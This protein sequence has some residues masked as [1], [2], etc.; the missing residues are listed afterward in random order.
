M[1]DS[2]RYRRRQ[3]NPAT[4]SPAA[5]RA[6]A[7]CPAAGGL[8]AGSRRAFLKTA[9]AA[10]LA[11][12]ADVLGFAS[13]L[14]AAEGP[15]AARPRVA[16]VTFR[17][18][19]GGGCVWPPSTT[20]ELA[21]TQKLH[22][23]IMQDAAA[24]YGVDLTVLS[25]RVTDVAATLEQIGQAKPDGL[26]VVAMDFDLGPMT[27]LCQ[28][29]GEVPAI[30]YGNIVHM[31]R[32]FEPVRRLPK[33]L[34][35]HTSDVRW[36][37]TA[38]RMHR[39]L[40]DVGRL[41]LLDCPCPGYYEELKK[42]EAGDQLKAIADFYRKGATSIE[43]ACADLV[44]DSARHYVVLRRLMGARECNGVTVAGP[45]CVGAGTGGHLPACMAV[46]K[47]M[48]E[49]VPA[50][51]QGSHTAAFCQ[52]LAFSLFGRPGFMGN[53]TFDSVQNHLILSH[54]TSALRLEGF[55]SDYR[56]P[57]AL[58]CFHANRGV[59]LQVSWP[60]GKEVTIL[61][62]MS[63]KDNLLTVASG[64]VVAGNEQIRQPPCGG[65]R[66]VVQFRLDWQGDIMDL[67]PSDDLHASAILGNLKRPLILFSKLAGLA[68]VDIAGKPIAG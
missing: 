47:L 21:A 48:D 50:A 9:G 17:K 36:L 43:P 4:R 24:R 35:A 56:A 55:A 1:S 59:S 30:I 5:G 27:Q 12:Q 66:T 20:E 67:H 37:D 53:L 38:V 63:M 33:T 23:R 3:N 65:C 26:I 54:C 14:L 57:F 32:A 68:P 51:C 64:R 19:H 22:E 29:R 13:S 2:C 6:C 11:A 61:D 7:G 44:L 41:K 10:V 15:P 45:L 34:L 60:V 40:W 16:V 52:R 28:K 25:E 58:R 18:A 39:A 31:G 46:S 49:G 8:P 62:R 42:V